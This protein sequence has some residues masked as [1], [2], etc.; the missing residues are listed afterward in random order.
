MQGILK[1]AANEPS[2]KQFVYT[3]SSTA[4]TLPI[5]NKEFTI[6]TNTWNETSI[7]AAWAPPPYEDDRAWAVYASSKTEGEKALWKFM[8]EQKPGFVANAILPNSNYGTILANAQPTTTGKWIRD[9]Y[10]GNTD[11]LKGILP[12]MLHLNLIATSFADLNLQN[13]SSMSK[14]QLDFTLPVL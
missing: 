13:G 1:S 11:A 6:D 14:I 8:E 3:F 12:R 9:L 10:D 4:A 2:V 5:P 7:K